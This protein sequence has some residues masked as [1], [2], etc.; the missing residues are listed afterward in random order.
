MGCHAA[1]GPD[2]TWAPKNS[3]GGC[4]VELGVESWRLGFTGRCVCFFSFV[5]LLILKLFRFRF[6]VSGRPSIFFNGIDPRKKN[7]GGVKKKFFLMS[8]NHQKTTLH[9]RSS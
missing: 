7:S 4:S 2:P 1:V 5:F 8:W 9:I 3:V 6:Q